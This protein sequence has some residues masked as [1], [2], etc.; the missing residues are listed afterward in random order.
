MAYAGYLI[1]LRVNSD[2]DPEYVAAF[3]NTR[4][5]KT[6]L[7]GMCKSIIGMANINAMELRSIKITEPP[8]ALQR[9]FARRVAATERA[10]AV[11]RESSVALDRLFASLQHRA[12]RGEL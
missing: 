3:L 5:S 7:R 6:V 10:K 8:L 1:R 12:F 4:H 2:N 9:E 11:C